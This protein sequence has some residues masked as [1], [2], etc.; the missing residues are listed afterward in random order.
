MT[1]EK[2]KQK[3]K[4][5][6]TDKKSE[7]SIKLQSRLGQGNKRFFSRGRLLLF[8]LVLLSFFFVYYR[9]S[10][11]KN[12]TPVKV[13]KN[14]DK[15]V[16]IKWKKGK[17]TS[18]IQ[19]NNE[20]WQIINKEKVLPLK[21]NKIDN[22]LNFLAELEAPLT[23]LQVQ[24]QLFSQ[25]TLETKKYSHSLKVFKYE[26][27]FFLS[28]SK[29]TFQLT[30]QQYT[31]LFPNLSSWIRRIIIPHDIDKIG[32]IKLYV[33]TAA[34]KKRYLVT[35]QNSWWIMGK[36]KRHH[37]N[38]RFFNHYLETIKKISMQKLLKTDSVPSKTPTVKIYLK[39]QQVIEVFDYQQGN[40]PKKLAG[41]A[42]K[43]H[44]NKIITFCTD[45]TLKN[46]L[47]PTL[48][49]LLEPRI[50]P[51]PPTSPWIK[52]E[53]E[54]NPQSK[55]KLTYSKNQQWELFC[56]NTKKKIDKKS[57]PKWIRVLNNSLIN[58]IIDKSEFK[59]QLFSLKFTS[60]K[61]VE[62]KIKVG[63]TKDGSPVIIRQGED[64]AGL[65]RQNIFN[66]LKKQCID[67]RNR[68]LF[69]EKDIT[70]IVRNGLGQT[71]ILEIIKN[72]VIISKP[73]TL[74]FFPGYLQKILAKIKEAEVET[75]LSRSQVKEKLNNYN[76]AKSSNKSNK[77]KSLNNNH[78][79]TELL[80]NQKNSLQ[81]SIHNSSQKISEFYIHK[82]LP[83][84][85]YI[86]KNLK[87]KFFSL[88][89]KLHENLIKP[90][91]PDNIFSFDPLESRKIEFNNNT[92]LQKND[93]WL[94]T[95]NNGTKKI[96]TTEKMNKNLQ[97]LIN[98]LKEIK[99][100][101][102]ADKL[103]KIDLSLVFFSKNNK[104]QHIEI[105]KVK[106]G[107]FLKN[108]LWSAIFHI[109]TQKDIF[110]PLKF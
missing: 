46:K 76:S 33:Q 80:L 35:R 75:F 70:S 42:I 22:F 4:H 49:Q 103:K 21:R 110:K 109:K 88:S 77:P 9:S 67:F 50:L 34:G 66:H 47:V 16:E 41:L 101:S 92:V 102:Y 65:I 94:L 81:I 45:Q 18:R 38:T 96:I 64:I 59:N 31:K 72:K 5:N 56:N 15:L 91:I 82:K 73:L 32:K 44:S 107:Y 36:K 60:Q 27:Q 39:N 57:G 43:T 37:T 71:E 2:I 53:V 48:P 26:N 95:R 89:E 86:S 20:K 74:P 30:N 104:K 79:E 12:N 52:V 13:F 10:S 3:T 23:S 8:G 58:K 69:P 1:E 78:S 14:V 108:K 97:K 84:G 98:N 85:K 62:W 6:K 100:I 61:G 106:D 24:P 90:W 40:C 68:R 99:A 83:L 87:R 25:L 105:Q 17:N 29:K 63:K 55:F 7:P 93:Y 11:L 28:N 19:L 54:Y 51:F